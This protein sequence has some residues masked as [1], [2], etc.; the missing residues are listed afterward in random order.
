MLVSAPQRGPESPVAGGPLLSWV[1]CVLGFLFGEEQTPS[2][3]PCCPPSSSAVTWSL[4]LAPRWLTASPHVESLGCI[5]IPTQS[6]HCWGPRPLS[7]FCT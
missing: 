1:S 4:K 7:S 2:L 6:F 5:E 3:L